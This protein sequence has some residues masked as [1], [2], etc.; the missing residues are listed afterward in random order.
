LDDFLLGNYC[1]WGKTTQMFDR[2]GKIFPRICVVA[3]V[4]TIARD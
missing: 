1:F 3:M 4:R 2:T